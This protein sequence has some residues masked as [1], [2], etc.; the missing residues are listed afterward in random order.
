M[1]SQLI[2]GKH[3]IPV[4][5]GCFGGYVPQEWVFTKPTSRGTATD[6]CNEDRDSGQGKVQFSAA[7]FRDRNQ[8]LQSDAVTEDCRSP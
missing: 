5:D 3:D 2:Q 8:A 4:A 7:G 6:I 1:F